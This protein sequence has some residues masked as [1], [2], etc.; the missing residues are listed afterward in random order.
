M[1]IVLD[2]SKRKYIQIKQIKHDLLRNTKLG[3]KTN[4]T[5]LLRYTMLD[6]SE[7]QNTNFSID[8]TLIP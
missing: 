7:N 2:T 4:R 5:S 8:K 3:V 1:A 6:T